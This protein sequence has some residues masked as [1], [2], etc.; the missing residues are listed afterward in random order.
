METSSRLFALN[1]ISGGTWQLSEAIFAGFAGALG[2]GVGFALGGLAGAFIVGAAMLLKPAVTG[3]L[4]QAAMGDD[5]G[6]RF[7]GFL[8]FAIKFASSPVTSTI[9]LLIG[10]FGTGFGLWGDVEWFKGGVIAFEHNPGGG[11]FSAVTLGASVNIWQGD[12]DHDLF[13]HELYHSRQYTYFGDAFIPFWL[14]GGVY[15]LISSAAAGN[16]QW[17][18]FSS[19]NPNAGYGNPLEDGAHAAERGGGCT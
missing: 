1:A 17:D 9:G 14:L 5:F 2:V 15:G 16:F 7:L 8:S 11:G 3:A 19:G 13:A 12:T 18:C 10:G 4:D 6:S